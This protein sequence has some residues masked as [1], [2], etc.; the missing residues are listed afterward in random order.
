[1][2]GWEVSIL[3][4][5]LRLTEGMSDVLREP[6]NED[7]LDLT[8]A[9]SPETMGTWNRFESSLVFS[10]GEFWS[11]PQVMMPA[12]GALMFWPGGLVNGFAAPRF[13][14]IKKNKKIQEWR[15]FFENCA[16]FSRRVV[17]RKRM[18][19]LKSSRFLNGLSGCCQGFKRISAGAWLAKQLTGSFFFVIF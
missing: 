6:S 14:I 1:M 19:F 15:I 7:W 3:L 18:S 13:R 5:F 10:T 2:E 12:K 9:A 16:Y 4:S 17:I 8:D 11:W